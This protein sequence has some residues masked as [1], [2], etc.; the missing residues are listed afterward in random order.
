MA[1]RGEDLKTKRLE[2]VWKEDK[3]DLYYSKV[4]YTVVGCVHVP[5]R[6]C[7]KMRE[8]RVRAR[9]LLP[10][11]GFPLVW[12]AGFFPYC[13]RVRRSSITWSRPVLFAAF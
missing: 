11:P 1:V 4:C 3:V 6:G 12:G 2:E 8:A 9:A 5:T 13:Q 7:A 10:R